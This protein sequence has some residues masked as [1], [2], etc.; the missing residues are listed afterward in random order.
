MVIADRRTGKRIVRLATNNPVVTFDDYRT[1]EDD[2][3]WFIVGMKTPEFAYPR[4]PSQEVDPLA[5]FACEELEDEDRSDFSDLPDEDIQDEAAATDLRD[6]D[7]DAEDEWPDDAWPGMTQAQDGSHLASLDP[8]SGDDE[9]GAGAPRDL[10]DMARASPD[11]GDAGASETRDMR[12]CPDDRLDPVDV[13]RDDIPR[14]RTSH[15]G[16]GARTGPSRSGKASHACRDGTAVMA[17]EG[18]MSFSRQD[19]LRSGVSG[20]ALSVP[21]APSPSMFREGS[22]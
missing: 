9:T 8:S 5:S 10:H 2:L 6:Q 20:L 15:G 7:P 1:P 19:Q 3:V 22:G 16:T 14:S 13:P 11:Y 18:G 12:V 4:P 21:D 17:Q